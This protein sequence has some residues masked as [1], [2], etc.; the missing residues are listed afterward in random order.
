MITTAHDHELVSPAAGAT[1]GVELSRRHAM[2]DIF[3]KG[4]SEVR[5]EG[6]NKS[7]SDAG[8]SAVVWRVR[9]QLAGAK[10]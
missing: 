5:P 7:W 3:A 2:I 6:Q 10:V 4:H 8:R 9:D 1:L